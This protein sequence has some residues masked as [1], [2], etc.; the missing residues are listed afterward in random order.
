[1]W[2]PSLN[3]IGL[4]VIGIGTLLTVLFKKRKTDTTEVTVL[5]VK[6]RMQL[7]R[8]RATLLFASALIAA[9]SILSYFEYQKEIG[10]R[11]IAIIDEHL[12]IV[13]SNPGGV[14]LGLEVANM[15]MELNLSVLNRQIKSEIA[16]SEKSNDITAVTDL[17]SRDSSVLFKL[18][19]IYQGSNSNSK[20]DALISRYSEYFI[21]SVGS[22][23]NLEN[24][25]DSQRPIYIVPR[26][27]RSN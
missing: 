16:Q 8:S 1:M 27:P 12:A 10:I 4:I 22:K 14:S 21:R 26:Y 24:F 17:Y 19:K 25:M 20:A 2:I 23:E 3:A 15:E 5:G 18:F 7:S 11:N 9:G 6:N 13:Q